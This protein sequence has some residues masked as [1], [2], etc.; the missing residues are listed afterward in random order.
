MDELIAAA[1][2]AT[3]DAAR[4]KAYSDV[5]NIL[6]EEVP[7]AWLVEVDFPT[8]LDRRYKDVVVSAIGVSDT[9]RQAKRVG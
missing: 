8:V 4:Q 1:A 9:F 7:M 6:V 5:Q 2:A 3:D